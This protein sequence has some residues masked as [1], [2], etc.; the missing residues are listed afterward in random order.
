MRAH[1]LDEDGWIINTVLVPDLNF[2]PGL[3]DAAIGG[4]IGDRIVNG[5][6]IYV[7]TKDPNAPDPEPEDPPVDP[8]P[9]PAP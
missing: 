6:L 4:Q 3:V 9:D 2:I 7:V 1:L 8:E 5:V